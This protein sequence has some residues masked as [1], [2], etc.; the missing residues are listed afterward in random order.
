MFELVQYSLEGMRV[1]G[2]KHHIY[3]S[4]IVDNNEKHF[5]QS[6]ELSCGISVGQLCIQIF[7]Q[8]LSIG[9]IVVITSMYSTFDGQVEHSV[10]RVF[11]KKIVVHVAVC[12]DSYCE[13]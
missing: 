12:S 11:L 1:K 13:A 5:T 9:V 7:I 4:D 8:G 2:G 10:V 3:S 6:I